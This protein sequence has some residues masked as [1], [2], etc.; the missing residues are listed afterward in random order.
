MPD[1]YR[2]AFLNRFSDRTGLER[3]TFLGMY[4]PQIVRELL[5]DE[6]LL[7]PKLTWL[8]GLPGS[9]K[10]SF[11]RLLCIDIVSE[12]F[13]QKKTDDE[14]FKVLKES[15]IVDNNNKIIYIGI[16][17]PID[18]IYSEAENIT[19][20]S[21]YKDQLFYTIFNLRVAKQL[22]KALKTVYDQNDS[23]EIQKI[24][25]DRIPPAI[26]SETLD[27]D[28]FLKK[29]QTQ[30][31][32]ISKL[33]NSFPGSPISAELEFHI[34]FAS[35]DLLNAQKEYH[36]INFI[37]MIDDAHEL[38]DGQ[39]KKLSDAL[40]KREW[41]FPRWIAL[42]KHIFPLETLLE[43]YRITT[44]QRESSVIDIDKDILKNNEAKLFKP[45]IE[46]IYRVIWGIMVKY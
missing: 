8:L 6:N 1:I 34:R 44:D 21:K 27:A 3:S 2:N 46:R 28:L 11:L 10:T 9:G 40:S 20:D 45:F 13:K 35:F 36:N 7:L 22:I 5:K 31:E 39:L 41:F 29:V 18:D 14:V 37:L 26:F 15:G 43:P 19:L 33:L 38:Y 42:R 17:I 4:A 32:L 12:V 16:Y 25:P 24:P 30:E 23:I